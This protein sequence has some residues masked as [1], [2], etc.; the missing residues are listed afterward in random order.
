[1]KVREMDV[2]LYG[3]YMNT[4][5]AGSEPRWQY[6]E[7]KPC[8]VNYNGAWCSLAYDRRQQGF[9][10]YKTE[11]KNIIALLGLDKN[12][13]VIDIGCGTGAFA[14]NAAKH[15]KKVYAVDVSKAMLR[16]ARKKARKAKLDNIEFSKGGF[17]TYTHNA[18]PVD[19]IVSMSALHHLPDFWKMIG[20]QRLARMVK[21]GGKIYIKD[22]VFSFD[23]ARYES[24]I[25]AFIQIM[26]NRTEPGMKW[27]LETHF[28]QEYST[29]GWVM[30]GLLERAGFRIDKADY[31]DDFFAT[32][33]CTKK[34]E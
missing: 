10:D 11:S 25:K 28:R 19:A 3:N 9:R 23:L 12:Q 14:I 27:D 4:L 24:R 18:E 34:G 6:D 30:E 1:M 22:V 32:Y 8:G 31:K 7:M 26:L 15:L 21:T 5:E 13:K 29:C 33:L 16:R 20:L 17:L 2:E